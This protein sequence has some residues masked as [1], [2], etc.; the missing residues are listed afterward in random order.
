M[1]VEQEKMP[2]HK[3]TPKTIVIVDDEPDIIEL[4]TIHLKK[5]WIYSKVFCEW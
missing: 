4:V 2:I 5:K 1:S 3:S